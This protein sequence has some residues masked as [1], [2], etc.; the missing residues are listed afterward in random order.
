MRIQ[1]PSDGRLSFPEYDRRHAIRFPLKSQLRWT[2]LNRKTPLTGTGETV[3]ASSNGF[4]FLSNVPLSPGCRLQL[5]V[6]WPAE[7]D[8][9]IP[10]KLV[11]IGKVV[12]VDGN[13]VCVTIQKREF[14]TAGRKATPPAS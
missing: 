1:E 4:A 2:L 7:L 3:D 14:R 13:I 10:M 12:R 6:E 9:R 5:D 8:G 11:V